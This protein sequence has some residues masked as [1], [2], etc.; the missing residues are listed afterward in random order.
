M[1]HFLSAPRQ[2]QLFV[3]FLRTCKRPSARPMTSGCLNTTGSL[4][5]TST[6]S[7]AGPQ[8]A[9]HLRQSSSSSFR[10]QAGQLG[11][12]G[13]PEAAHVNCES[14]DSSLYSHAQSPHDPLPKIACPRG[15]NCSTSHPICRGFL[16][17]QGVS[18]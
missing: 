7:N 16:V 2:L 1:E 6:T 3:G 14:S 11:T 8:Q 18:V 15:C 9:P 12:T 17:Y 4:G 5:S 10:T 13:R